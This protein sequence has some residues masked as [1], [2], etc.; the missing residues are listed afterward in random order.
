VVTLE[1]PASGLLNVE[2]GEGGEYLDGCQCHEKTVQTD[3][4]KRL[5]IR[6]RCAA[7]QVENINQN[8]YCWIG[9]VAQIAYFVTN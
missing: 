7:K 9:I 8:P 3:L 1:A 5:A 4:D 6:Y 2:H